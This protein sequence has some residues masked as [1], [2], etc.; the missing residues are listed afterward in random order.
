MSGQLANLFRVEDSS[1]NNLFSI[2]SSGGIFA[3]STLNISGIANLYS[4][5]NVS[6]NAIFTQASSTLASTLDAFF[7]GRTATTTI[8]G[9][10]SATSTFAGGL[11]ITRGLQLNSGYVFGAGLEKEALVN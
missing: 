9:E 10:F 2:S 4:N 6:G 8:R 5:L 11:D 3:S 7:V 1:L